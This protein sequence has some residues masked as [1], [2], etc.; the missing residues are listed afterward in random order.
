[1]EELQTDIFSYLGTAI[2]DLIS[3]Y[4]GDCLETVIG[5]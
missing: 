4:V 3:Q 5:Q 2:C 1:M